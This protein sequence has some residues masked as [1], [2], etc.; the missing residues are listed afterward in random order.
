[1][2]PQ[3]SVAVSSEIASQLDVVGRGVAASQ[4]TMRKQLRDLLHVPE[5]CWRVPVLDRP[6][7]AAGEI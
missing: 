2:V 1:M 4:P 7:R 3:E 6:W 5:P